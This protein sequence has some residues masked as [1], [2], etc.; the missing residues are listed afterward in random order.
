MGRS[1]EVFSLINGC[2]G[3][4]QPEWME[5]GQAVLGSVRKELSK[6]WGSKPVSSLP[7][8]PL[9]QLL[10]PGFYLSFPQW[11]VVTCML[12]KPFS[13]QVSFGH[14]LLSQR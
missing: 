12:T 4:A 10:T 3:R 13:L 8:W 14:G 1:L 2:C 5:P 9:P 6:P 11:W 7:P